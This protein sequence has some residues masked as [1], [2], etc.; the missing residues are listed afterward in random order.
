[1]TKIKKGAKIVQR[2]FFGEKSPQS[3]HIFRGEKRV[4]I[5]IYRP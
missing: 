4:K 2:I 3:H 5:S 1:V